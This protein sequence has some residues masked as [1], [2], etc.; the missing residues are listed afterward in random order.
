M[1]EDESD[2]ED[3]DG[4]EE[5]DETALEEMEMSRMAEEGKNV[6]ECLTAELDP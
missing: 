1:Q 2:Y 6:A 4:D 3:E 5:M